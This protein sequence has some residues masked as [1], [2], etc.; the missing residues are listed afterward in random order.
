MGLPQATPV[1]V[2]RS[3]IPA[4]RRPDLQRVLKNSL[5]KRWNHPWGAA[6]GDVCKVCERGAQHLLI[7]SI[8][9]PAWA[10]LQSTSPTRHAEP[11]RQDLNYSSRP[12]ISIPGPDGIRLTT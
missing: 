11:Y 5:E 6:F 8:F 3:V 7:T 9:L 2:Q 10:S 4:A 12:S 1:R